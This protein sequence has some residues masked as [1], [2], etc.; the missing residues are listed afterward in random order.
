MPVEWPPACF[1]DYAEIARNSHGGWIPPTP[2]TRPQAVLER[3]TSSI[4][5]LLPRVRFA[6]RVPGVS[7][8]TR[9]ITAE[10][11]VRRSHR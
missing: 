1:Q 8:I 9:G 2:N 4:C 7:S 5:T 3:S 11:A 10:R 6:V